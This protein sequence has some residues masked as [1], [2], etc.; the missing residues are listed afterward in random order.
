MAPTPPLPDAVPGMLPT[1]SRLSP[2]AP[3][4][5][6]PPRSISHCLALPRRSQ[7]HPSCLSSVVRLPCC[8]NCC[9]VQLAPTLAERTLQP[10][11]TSLTASSSHNHPPPRAPPR[12]Q[13]PLVAP[14]GLS[15]CAGC[16]W[17]K[18]WRWHKTLVP[19]RLVPRALGHESSLLH[20]TRV[21]HGM[22]HHNYR[23]R[24]QHTRRRRPP[25]TLP[26]KE[27]LGSIGGST[28]IILTTRHIN[29]PFDGGCRLQSGAGA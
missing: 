2:A 9:V 25:P 6:P 10:A 27:V 12:T 11:R 20:P 16:P 5:L 17:N 8:A 28:I 4:P 23:S 29:G 1:Q 18:K 7:H 19:A 24:D 14:P 13:S 15:V 26:A 21:H 22:P 3:P